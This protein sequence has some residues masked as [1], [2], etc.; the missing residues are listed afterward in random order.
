MATELNTLMAMMAQGGRQG[1]PIWELPAYLKEKKLARQGM[2]QQ[3]LDIQG[4]F[5]S[6]GQQPQG[7]PLMSGQNAQDYVQPN[8]VPQGLMG[9]STSYQDI[10]PQLAQY[11]STRADA[12]RDLQANSAA[13]QTAARKAA[14]GPQPMTLAQL[15]T[16]KQGQARL[17]EQARHNRDL[18]AQALADDATASNDRMN[19]QVFNCQL[20]E[21]MAVPLF[22]KAQAGGV[23]ALNGADTYQLMNAFQKTILPPEAVMSDNLEAIRNAG[24]ALGM[25]EGWLAKAFA[26]D[27][28]GDQDTLILLE[29]VQRN[30][31]QGRHT[32]ENLISNQAQHFKNRTMY[33]FFNPLELND[34]SGYQG[35]G[36]ATPGGIGNAQQQTGTIGAP[37]QNN[38]WQALP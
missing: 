18:E 12:M 8:Q 21:N 17:D 22:K 37:L 15:S 32:I 20:I 29:A 31:G 16:E 28:L 23:G 30:L 35:I 10:L 26:R 1:R 36:A 25:S 7:A 19:T 13:R 9:A 6:L 4:L 34:L 38:P 33:Q 11:P 3:E 14:A 2:A 5:E 24:G 27:T